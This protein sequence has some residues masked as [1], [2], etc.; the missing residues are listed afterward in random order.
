MTV[1][2]VATSSSATIVAAHQLIRAI[3]AA[4]TVVAAALVTVIMFTVTS[5]A[6]R[7]FLTTI[8]VCHSN[9]PITEFLRLGILAKQ[10]CKGICLGKGTEDNYSHTHQRRHHNLFHFLSSLIMIFN[11]SK[12]VL[13]KGC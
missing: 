6:T 4:V 1:V 3:N 5:I 10:P 7:R 11:V 2:A 9:I 8:S 12:T 13:V